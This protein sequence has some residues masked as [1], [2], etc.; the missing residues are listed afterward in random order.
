MRSLGAQRSMQAKIRIGISLVNPLIMKPNKVGISVQNA[1][2][3]VLFGSLKVA[4]GTL[5]GAR[6]RPV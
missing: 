3:S 6:S 5:Y 4:A 2:A 1:Y